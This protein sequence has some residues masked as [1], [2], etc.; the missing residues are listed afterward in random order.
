ME[1]SSAAETWRDK[2]P[3][4]VYSSEKQTATPAMTASDIGHNSLSTSG[5]QSVAMRTLTGRP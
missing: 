4:T 1:I 2:Q 3:G 5:H